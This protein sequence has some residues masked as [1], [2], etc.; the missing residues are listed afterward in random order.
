MYRQQWQSR[1]EKCTSQIGCLDGCQS[2]QRTGKEHKNQLA[3][4]G[5]G[6]S[7]KELFMAF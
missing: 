6:E 3:K 5:G 1:H 7:G 2:E 4:I